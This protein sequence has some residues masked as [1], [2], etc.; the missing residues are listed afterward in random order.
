MHDTFKFNTLYILP[1]YWIFVFCIISEPTYAF[2]FYCIIT[3][4]ESVYC[5]LPP[6]FLCKTD[7][8]SSLKG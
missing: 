5:A 1:T 7:N 3:E 4:K 2:A 6:G 8:V